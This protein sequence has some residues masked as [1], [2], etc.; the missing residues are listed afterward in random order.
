M[1]VMLDCESD[2][3]FTLCATFTCTTV[4]TSGLSVDTKWR[5]A[6][7][8]LFVVITFLFALNVTILLFSLPLAS[9]TL[10]VKPEISDDAIPSSVTHFTSNC[11]EPFSAY[12][13]QSM[14]MTAPS[15]YVI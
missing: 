11:L 8:A 10:H 3:L 13:P 1:R 15:S 5:Y 14:L 2:T 6:I 4:S 12:V 7:P 9:V